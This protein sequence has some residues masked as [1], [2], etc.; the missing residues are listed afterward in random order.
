MK[1]IITENYEEMSK[2]AADLIINI[3]KNNPYAVLGLATG[4][5]PIGTYDNMVK[6]HLENGTSYKN[7]RTV[8]LDEYVSLSADHDQ[9]YA[10]FMRK[11]LFDRVD[12]DLANTNLPSG[13][14]PDAQAECDRYNALLDTMKQDIQLLGLGSNGH[15]GFNEP[16]TPFGSV[17]H[18]VDLTENTI[19]DNSRLFDNINDVPRQAL[20]MGIKNIMQADSILMVVSG[21]NKADAVYGMVKGDVTPDLPASVLQLH[22]NVTIVCDKAAASKL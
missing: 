6:D 7:V 4:S 14:A 21:A 20:S 12:I 9:S 17:T 2:V 5:S 1:V 8:N 11:N 3:V 22:P 16:G 18:L 15:I 10:Y 19:K 13:V